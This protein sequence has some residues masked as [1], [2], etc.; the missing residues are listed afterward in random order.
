MRLKKFVF[1]TLTDIEERI[2]LSERLEHEAPTEQSAIPLAQAAEAADNENQISTIRQ[3]EEISETRK[4]SVEVPITTK[5]PRK[6]SGL[7]RRWKKFKA[8]L[9]L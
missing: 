7:K 9:R 1:P 8:R 4:E 5:Q 3:A 6:E 2:K